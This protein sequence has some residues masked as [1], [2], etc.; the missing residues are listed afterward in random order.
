[1]KD[2]TALATVN[3][4]RQLLEQGD[5]DGARL[6]AQQ[7]LRTWP[8][9]AS[10]QK[11]LG[12][13][14]LRLGLH[15][16]AVPIFEALLQEGGFNPSIAMQLANALR[17]LGQMEKAAATYREVLDMQ[18]NNERAHIGLIEIAFFGGEIPTA[19]SSCTKALVAVP[20]NQRIRH[21][22]A[23]CLRSLGK[24]NEAK[25]I[26]ERLLSEQPQNISFAIELATTCQ[27]LGDLATADQLFRRVLAA[28]PD[29][30]H[31]LRGIVAI[32]E[33]TYGAN[34]AIKILETAVGQTAS[35]TD[36]G[37]AT[38]CMPTAPRWSL[39]LA[40]LCIKV[41]DQT[42]AAQ[43]LLS[44]E[45]SEQVIPENELVL[46]I[47]L[48]ERLG[49][50]DVLSGLVM[51]VLEMSSIRLNLAL[52]VLQ[53]AL[54][55]EDPNL[56]AKAQEEMTRRIHPEDR[57]QFRAE[58]RMLTVGPL[59]ALA[60]I[61]EEPRARRSA[62]EAQLLS[63]FLLAA[64]RTRL[65]L[66]YLR[67]CSRRWPGS[68]RIRS[69]LISSFVANGQNAE[70]LA[71]LDRER[72]SLAE[73]EYKKLRLRILIQTDAYDEALSL[74]DQ[75]LQSGQ[76]AKSL[77]QRLRLL[78]ALGRLEDA[79]KAETAARQ[80]PGQRRSRAAH[81]G[82]TLAGTLLTELRMYRHALTSVRTLDERLAL[83]ETNY[84]AAF[85]EIR[86]HISST[87]PAKLRE[88]S[89][90]RRIVQYWND[91]S[92]PPDISAAMRS[93]Q[94]VAGWKYLRLDRRD[95]RYWLAATLGSDHARAF[96][97]ARHVAEEADFLR[98]CLLFHGGGIYA[99]ADDLLV[100]HPDTI[101]SEGSGMVVFTEIF[102]AICNNLIC[103]PPGHPALGRAVALVKDAL[104]RR[105]ND[106][107]WLKT[108]PGALTRAIAGHLASDGDGVT[109]RPQESMLA[110]VR[111]HLKLPY[112]RGSRYWNNDQTKRLYKEIWGS[113]A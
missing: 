4:C 99:D 38:P 61:L 95:A 57:L 97:L 109:I 96:S 29:S 51:R 48:S 62:R 82:S 66:R 58:E 37:S 34:A 30:P 91:S 18:P 21:L 55:T 81:F 65:A 54:S 68:A 105:D 102:G 108:G 84:H 26:L 106:S 32:A 70:A 79:E 80:D 41:G 5:V 77:D 94:G 12:S 89:I 92:P 33:A 52:A 28:E 7:A 46:F 35:N 73:S 104:L 98:Y 85:E 45:K 74:L 16:E 87:A 101:V 72:T 36:S 42:R 110:Q 50:I 69:E 40:N 25:V 78:I 13:C 47:Q 1:M 93:W 100:G 67:F 103:A 3:R 90:P 64:G 53:L 83:I 8:S 11:L 14:M 86:S 23:R 2:P 19:F 88:S 31:A 20:E 59:D 113:T 15:S 76:N 39:H 63:R 9:N 10:L 111:P 75:Q 60:A 22:H 24:P 6:L 17:R 56:V 27:E 43:I 107:V 44:L 112:K 71:W 49:Q